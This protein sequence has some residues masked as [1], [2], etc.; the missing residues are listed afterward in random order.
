M[1]SDP[2]PTSD[3]RIAPAGGKPAGKRPH[4]LRRLY[5]WT[6]HWAHTPYASP[7][8]AV[9]SFA[10]ASFFPIPPDPL[11][12]AMALGRRER[13]FR[14]ATLC[15]A[16][17]VLGGI[18]GFIIG[19]FFMEVAGYRIIDF[20]DKRA[21]FDKVVH[22]IGPWMLLWVLIAAFS[23]IPYKVFTIAAGIVAK[24][25]GS[26]LLPFFLGFVITS[27]IGRS[28]RFFLVAW[29]IH[30]YGEPIKRLIDK[31]FNWFALAFAVLLVGAAYALRYL[32]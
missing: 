24:D 17:S 9:M 1:V 20:Y 5:D 27:T 14:Y 8:L 18:F 13:S 12:M 32:L 16:A 23:P 22:E 30:R 11:L 29:L 10:E 2:T 3:A 6:L 21:F 31:Y 7:A 26:G 19:Y 15:S 25:T 28:L 4:L